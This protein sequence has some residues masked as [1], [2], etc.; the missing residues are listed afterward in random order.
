V[1][2]ARLF[3]AFPSVAALI[4]WTDRMKTEEAFRRVK[5]EKNILRTTK[6]KKAE[7]FGHILRKNCLLK[8]VIEGKTQART[9]VTRRR[10]RRGKQLL[11]Y[12]KEMGGYWK[13]EVEALYRPLW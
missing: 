8:H 9:E 7:R 13:L 3:P 12:L 5:G 1:K 6:R 11:D 4:S 10:G 2:L